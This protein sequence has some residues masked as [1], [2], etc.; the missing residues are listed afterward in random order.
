MNP[1]I[2]DTNIHKATQV[3]YNILEQG[4]KD[5]DPHA[6]QES[7][8]SVDST[9]LDSKD[10]EKAQNKYPDGGA[11]LAVSH[12]TNPSTACLDRLPG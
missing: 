8:I 11:F 12:Y 4:I 5:F 3:S 6:N 7:S 9:A 1:G 2:F 10:T